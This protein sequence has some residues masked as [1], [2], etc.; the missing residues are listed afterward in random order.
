VSSATSFCSA[1]GRP[2]GAPIGRPGPL[3]RDGEIR[4]APAEIEFRELRRR[5]TV[6]QSSHPAV[7]DR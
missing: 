4:P 5:L 3:A 6:Y 7:F 1:S 2:A